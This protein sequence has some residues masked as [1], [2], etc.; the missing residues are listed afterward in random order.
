[1]FVAGVRDRK[2][3]EKMERINVITLEHNEIIAAIVAIEVVLR[4][5]GKEL[6]VDD[7]EKYG[8]LLSSQRK[9][10]KIL[11]QGQPVVAG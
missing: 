7:P 3:V 8:F 5:T 9:L 6:A 10:H 1:L 4:H 2:E 11:H